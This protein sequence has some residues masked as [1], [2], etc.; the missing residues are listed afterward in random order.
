MSQNKVPSD[1]QINLEK[2]ISQKALQKH[3]VKVFSQ[4]FTCGSV[5]AMSFL[6]LCWWPQL[7]A[8]QQNSD[9]LESHSPSHWENSEAAAKCALWSSVVHHIS[10][11]QLSSGRTLYQ[12]EE[13]GSKAWNKNCFIYL[14][15]HSGK[16]KVW[17]QGLAQRP[18]SPGSSC[19]PGASAE[20]AASA[21]SQRAV[22][23]Q[24]GVKQGKAK[25]TLCSV[26]FL[27]PLWMH[28]IFSSQQTQISSVTLWL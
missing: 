8:G 5:N 9:E 16:H 18:A 2:Q 14:V 12:N 26:G 25:K 1:E 6:W 23:F 7:T 28:N 17:P 10:P 20:S 21:A 3:Q 19:S 24:E 27:R 13:L 11:P 15:P 22:I 4:Q